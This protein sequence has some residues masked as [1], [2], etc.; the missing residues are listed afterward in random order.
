MR[1]NENNQEE[2]DIN[3]IIAKIKE[4]FPVNAVRDMYKE[5][6]G[7]W[8]DDY[9]EE[10]SFSG[11]AEE[12]ILNKLLGWFQKQYSKT[13]SDEKFDEAYSKLQD[14]YEFLKH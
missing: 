6:C 12:V 7:Q 13:L 5:E 10:A 4:E 9:E 3:F 8:S 14:V 2:T 11:V 1:F